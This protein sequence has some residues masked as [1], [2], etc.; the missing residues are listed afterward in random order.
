MIGSLELLM[1][2]CQTQFRL[3]KQIARFHDHWL[4]VGSG[5]GPPPLTTKRSA[6]LVWTMGCSSFTG[7]HDLKP[8]G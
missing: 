5:I 6:V 2:S 1:W 8:H 3:N 7:E 4:T